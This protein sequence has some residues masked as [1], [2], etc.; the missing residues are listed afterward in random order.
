MIDG[1]EIAPL[2]RRFR[3]NAALA[4][5]RDAAFQEMIPQV[6]RTVLGHQRR[7]RFHVGVRQLVAVANQR[8][9]LIDH[10]I[11]LIEIRGLAFDQEIVAVRADADVEERFEVLEILVVRAEQRLDPFLGDSNAFH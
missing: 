6:D 10:A 1:V 2:I 3:R 8:R 11:D 7:C 9:Q 5:R 4:G